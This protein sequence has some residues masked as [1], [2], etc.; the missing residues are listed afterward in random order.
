MAKKYVRIGSF[1]PFIYD[2][3]QQPA[4]VNTD[5]DIQANNVITDG[6][7]ANVR[8]IASNANKKVEEVNDLTQWIAGG[9]RVTIADDGDGT[10][11]VSVQNLSDLSTIDDTDSPFTAL[12]TNERNYVVADATNGAITVNLPPAA[13][14]VGLEIIVKKLD[15]AANNVTVSPDG[16]ETIDGASSY[17]LVNQWDTVTLYSDGTQI[18]VI[19]AVG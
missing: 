8:L 1:G 19:A 3:S 16:T 14:W 18:L 5:G 17:D 9:D 12:H 4:A 6:L 7:S 13:D 10:V 2:D 11:T 15:T